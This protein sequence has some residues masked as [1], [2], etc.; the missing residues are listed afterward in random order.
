MSRRAEVAIR[1]YSEGDLP[2][3][4]RTLG[5][6]RMM[7]HLGGPE[8]LEKLRERHKKFVAMSEGS[9]A[10]CMFV[11]TIGSEKASAGLGPWAF[12]SSSRAPLAEHTHCG[13]RSSWSLTWLLIRPLWKTAY[14]RTTV[15][16][17]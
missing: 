4:E 2:W 5:D 15:T 7:K 1:P 12:Y 17:R 9:S 10:G 14:L 8:G 11:T 16:L 13:V 3:L 6:P